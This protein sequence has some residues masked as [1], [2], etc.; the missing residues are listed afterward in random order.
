MGTCTGYVFGVSLPVIPALSK[1]KNYFVNSDNL[2][3]FSI[4]IGLVQIIFG[5]CVAAYKI[6]IQKGTKHSIAPFAWA[7]AFISLAL[8]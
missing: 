3:T 7:F 5:K 8:E 6:K 2:M 1:I 4:V